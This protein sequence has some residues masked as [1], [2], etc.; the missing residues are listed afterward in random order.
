MPSPNLTSNMGALRAHYNDDPVD[1]NPAQ[2]TT[3][4]S[5]DEILIQSG[6]ATLDHAQQSP[7]MVLTL[8]H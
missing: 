2:G 5:T 7:S 8:L 1:E 3:A 6:V 4:L